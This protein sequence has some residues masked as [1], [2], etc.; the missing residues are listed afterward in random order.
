M[1]QRDTIKLF[2][3]SVMVEYGATGQTGSL[4]VLRLDREVRFAI[5]GDAIRAN[6]V[7][8][9]APALVERFASAELAKN[10]YH[11]LQSVVKRYVFMRRI[12]SGVI[13]LTMWG[14]A[15]LLLTV[16][17]L[18]LNLALTR[19][20]DAHAATP[21]AVTATAAAPA[22]AAA[23]QAVATA[24]PAE[25]ARAMQDGTR[26]G[27]YSIP[28]SSGP[29]GT[30][31]VFTDPA[32]SYCRDLEP[33]LAKLAKNY[34]IH[35]FPVSVIGGKSSANAMSGIMCRKPHQRA[36]AWKTLMSRLST[37]DAPC[38]DGNDAIAAN[39]K[40]FFTAGFAGTP[41][42]IGAD[43]S[44]YPDAGHNTE[45]TILRWLNRKDH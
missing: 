7:S 8:D 34:T 44:I 25:L 3:H 24:S 20:M 19:N 38:K 37:T 23:A 5:E 15:P 16:T 40:I 26:S 33:E 42:I 27:R 39:D 35:L 31:Y 21:A 1:K 43:G 32:C 13:R 28:L 14:V 4:S 9:P 2:G 29:R 36:V 22:I 10:A 30:F 17:V 11:H 18:T 12:R 45:A 6:Y 41:A